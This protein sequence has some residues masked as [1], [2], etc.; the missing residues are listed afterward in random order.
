MNY[1][2]QTKTATQR[3]VTLMPGLTCTDCYLYTGAGFLV[4]AQYSS[5]NYFRA[6]VKVAGGAGFNVNLS[7]KNPT[8]TATK[9]INI[10]GA[11]TWSTIVLGTGLA[12]QYRMGGV[13]ADISGSGTA[14]G[15]GSA[16]G[17]AQAQASAGFMYAAGKT[18]TPY[19]AFASYKKPSASIKF[20]SVKAL[21]AMVQVTGRLD[22][23]VR[24][25]LTLQT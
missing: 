3:V 16:V 14:V 21:S 10:A 23:K 6:E 5:G 17:G 8:I 22:A 9:T 2:W 12:F 20:T 24:F 18:Y 25:T 1:N 19:T 11:G 13:R 7:A 15:T 4:I